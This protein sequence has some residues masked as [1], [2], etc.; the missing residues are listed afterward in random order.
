M[1]ACVV[2]TI[3]VVLVFKNWASVDS[4]LS[5]EE[6]ELVIWL[7]VTVPIA[8]VWSLFVDNEFFEELLLAI[9]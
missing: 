3:V 2:M 9:W 7:L 6:L 1:I 8:V 5:F 4:V